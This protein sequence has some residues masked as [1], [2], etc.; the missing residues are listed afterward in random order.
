[1]LIISNGKTV[2][3]IPFYLV[4]KMQAVSSF[5]L[6]P[7]VRMTRHVKISGQF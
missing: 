3:N 4:R 2:G 6:N 7:H 5:K 1:M